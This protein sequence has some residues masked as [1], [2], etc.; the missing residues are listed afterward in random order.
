KDGV[1]ATP[2]EI[3]QITGKMG[4]VFQHFNLF[5][6]LTVK[7]NLEL[8]PKMLKK[9]LSADIHQRSGEL[10]ERIG[11]SDR[12]NAYPANLSG[13]QKQRVAIA[14]ALMMNPEFMLFDE[15]TSA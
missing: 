12:A 11:L 9:E 14:R 15:P 6:H 13:G 2:Q 7:E 1:Y 10:L 5:P 8:A 3:R 4:M